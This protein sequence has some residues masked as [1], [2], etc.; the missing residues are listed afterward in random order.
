M[1][2]F[3]V[4]CRTRANSGRVGGLGVCHSY[5]MHGTACTACAEQLHQSRHRDAAEAMKVEQLLPCFLCRKLYPRCHSL[6]VPSRSTGSTYLKRYLCVPWVVHGLCIPW[7]LTIA[8]LQATSASE[9]GFRVLSGAWLAPTYVQQLVTIHSSHVHVFD[10]LPVG[11][12]F[13]QGCC[14][15]A[16]VL[17]I[18]S[19][20]DLTA[21]QLLRLFATHSF[22]DALWSLV[23]S[24]PTSF[25]KGHQPLLRSVYVF[26]GH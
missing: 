13:L 20:S 4:L 5:G 8:P 23:S 25:H 2:W 21:F 24:S 3:V 15:T 9:E 19:L 14:F 16:V 11:G 17:E 12:M 6:D 10:R 22:R 7:V 1:C 18:L 26:C